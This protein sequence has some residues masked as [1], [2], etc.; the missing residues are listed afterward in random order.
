MFA[1]I[2]ALVALMNSMGGPA[3]APANLVQLFDSMGGPAA[4]AS[5]TAGDSMGGPA[6]ASASDSMGGPAQ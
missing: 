1:L 2:F 4:T 6:T 3:A 5:A